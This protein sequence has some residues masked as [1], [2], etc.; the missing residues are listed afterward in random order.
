[1]KFLLALLLIL[2]ALPTLGAQ[3][4]S[5]EKVKSPPPVEEKGFVIQ[6][7]E[8]QV[9]GGEIDKQMRDKKED[10]RNNKLIKDAEKAMKDEVDF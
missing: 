6:M 4:P 1:M 5:S 7:Q 3:S 2:G 9:R 10:K 8:D